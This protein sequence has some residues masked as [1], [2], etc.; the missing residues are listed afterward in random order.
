MQVISLHVCLWRTIISIS[1]ASLVSM[2][3]VGEASLVLGIISS[4]IAIIDATKQI[5]DAVE[6]EGGLPE[7]FKKS[8]AKLPLISNLLRDAERYVNDMTNEIDKAAFLLTLKDCKSQ[9]VQLNDL[10]V[11]VIPKEGSSRTDRYV[12]A[13][14]TIGKGGRVESLMRGILDSLHL[15]TMKFP[16]ITKPGDKKLLAEAIAEVL[17]MEPSLPDK[18]KPITFIPFDRNDGLV[19]RKEFESLDHLLNSSSHNRSAAIWGLGGCGKTQIA[20]EYAYRCQD[21]NSCSIFWIRADSEA[22]FIQDYSDLAKI[23]RLPSDLKAEDLLSAVKRWIENQRDWV[24]VFDNADDLR[25]FKRSYSPSETQQAHDPK[26]L[27]FVPRSQTGTIIW[28]SR[29]RRICGTITDSW[30]GIEVKAMDNEQATNLFRNLSE[31]SELTSS[32]NE[33]SILEL[34]ESLGNLP[35]AIVQ[36]AS[37]IRNTK[38]SVPQYLKSFE[39][40]QSD[41]LN[42]EFQ[43]LYRHDSD[44]PNAVMRTWHISMKKIA[45]ESP[46]TERILNIITFFNN[47]GIPFELIKAAAGA[48]YSDHEVRLAASRLSDY[49][50][51]QAQRA[52]DEDL[53]TYEQHRLVQLATRRSLSRAQIFYFS[54]EALRIMTSLFPDG[55]YETWN[56]CIIYLP[57]VLKIVTW[58]QAKGYESQAPLVLQRVGRYYW[59]QGNSEKAEEL[60]IEVLALQKE[61]LGEKHPDTILAMGNL[62]STWWQQGYS[63]KAEKLQ[64]EVLA[65]QKEILGEKHL[66]TITAMASLASTWWQQGYSEKAEKLQIEVLALQKEILGEKHLDTILAMANLASTWWQQG[67]SEKAEKLQIEVLALR[68]EILGE[69][70]PDTILAMA[71]LASTWWQHVYSEKAE[72]LQIE[73]LALRKEILGE[74]HPDTIL[75]MASLASTWWQQGYSEKSEKLDIEVLALQKEI[76]G[77]KHPDTILAMANLASTWWQQGYSEKAEKLQIEV[78]VLRKKILGEKHPNTVAA[79]ASLAS[80]W[81]QQGCSE[82]AEELEI[83]VLAL[84]KEILGEK[85]LDTITAM[86]NLASTWW[87][88]GYS[89]KAEKL[90]IEVLALRKEILGE[91]HLDTILAMGNLASTW[92]QQGYSKKAEKLQIEVLALQKEILGEKHPDTILTMKNLT[93]MNQQHIHNTNEVR[94]NDALSSRF[95]KW[96]RNAIRFGRPKNLEER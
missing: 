93:E 43:D 68:K 25:I 92:R 50:L 45:E 76:L 96:T 91:K 44:I 41:L 31:I 87:Q 46:C 35:L 70:H 16:E 81:W 80:T 36:A 66:D 22:T 2:S 77:E 56:N 86:A 40:E 42:E 13:A 21:K 12:K 90:D 11:K 58:S 63:K 88:Q 49:S 67:Y 23:S 71:I 26:L 38:I 47:K 32:K 34:L 14:R 62:A 8:S 4:I 33:K 9:A 55:T 48:T 95:K 7:N 59:E 75:A 85:H 57:H 61:I 53:P 24:I 10:F 5:Y 72:K 29:D 69:K 3:G 83:E 19:D 6:D 82:K 64:I 18:L 94:L 74:K 60:D 65:L 39:S 73:V 37:Y 17:K 30:R 51:I 20:L 27:R 15:L 84:R 28:T 52:L 78:L 89:E 1:I 79:M 54:G